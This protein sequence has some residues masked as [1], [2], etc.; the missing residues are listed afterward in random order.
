VFGFVEIAMARGLDDIS[1]H[2]KNDVANV[3]SA[4]RLSLSEVRL[5]HCVGGAIQVSSR[6]LD[7]PSA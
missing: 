1:L 6:D 4:S 7:A 5:S 2:P 3:L